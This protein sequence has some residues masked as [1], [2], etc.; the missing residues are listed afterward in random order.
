MD[1]AYYMQV[2][3]HRREKDHTST[4][5]PMYSS[6]KDTIIE[7]IIHKNNNL[8]KA[9]PSPSASIVVQPKESS[10]T[11]TSPKQNEV[12]I[13]KINL[14][15]KL[16]PKTENT[17][18]A[19]KTSQILLNYF[20]NSRS[21]KRIF[22][23]I[24]AHNNNITDANEMYVKSNL[25]KAHTDSKKLSKGQCRQVNCFPISKSS[26]KQTSKIF[27][28]QALVKMFESKYNL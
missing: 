9:I 22:T 21:R 3:Q 7:Y 18:K 8:H 16:E 17:W 13:K 15:L 2:M 20:K 14:H 4:F 12:Q 1:Y 5:S 23:N 6:R 26:A 25:Q 10:L 27:H 24:K 28:N 19:P 11:L